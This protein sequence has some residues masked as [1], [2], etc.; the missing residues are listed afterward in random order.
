M[1]R[2]YGIS[3]EQARRSR[4]IRYVHFAFSIAI[5]QDS[6]SMFTPYYILMNTT[7]FVLTADIHDAE[8]QVFWALCTWL[9]SF[10]WPLSRYV[11]PIMSNMILTVTNKAL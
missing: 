5:V 10:I 6:V 1:S 9:P 4:L 2:Q 3:L 11:T 8:V 7:S